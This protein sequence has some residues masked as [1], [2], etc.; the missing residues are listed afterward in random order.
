MIKIP[1]SA[2]ELRRRIETVKPGWL[3]D[4]REKTKDAK[5]AGHVSEGT[6]S[7][8]KE[9]FIALQ[10]H[11]CAYCESPMAKT[12]EGSADKVAV[13]YDV[14]HFR[15]KN[16]VTAWP[17]PEIASRRPGLDY[18]AEVRTGTA[19]GYVRFAF[20]PTNYLV[21]CKVCNSSYK[22]DRF[23][24]AG[25]AQKTLIDRTKL[26]QREMPLL[27]YPLGDQGDDPADH[28]SFSG[29]TIRVTA[30]DAHA[31]LRA[32]TLIDFFELDTREDLL[33]LRSLMILTLHPNLVERS[34]SPSASRRAKAAEF[35]ATVQLV[36]FPHA[37]CARA[38][39]ALYDADPA[40]AGEWYDAARD[41]WS[42]KDPKVLA[43]L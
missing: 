5:K 8:I 35:V 30:I 12:T 14:E 34:S 23:P 11:K 29:P 2:A 21:S 31:R 42:T 16:R 13:D 18:A 37:A 4:A 40:R 19:D 33:E 20:D 7:E 39:V 6:W 24:I 25:K 43:S 10:C 9:V 1:V 27:L 15:P 17:T 41:Y 28:L 22:S 36:R 32:R 38:F 26:D 3:D